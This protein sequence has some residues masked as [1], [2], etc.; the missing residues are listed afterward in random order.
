M[1]PIWCYF[2]NAFLL[3]MRLLI[4]VRNYYLFMRLKI[5]LNLLSGVK[6]H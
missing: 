6:M 3:P 4:F 1:E 5:I 2:L